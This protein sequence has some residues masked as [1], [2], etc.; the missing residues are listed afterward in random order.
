[1]DAGDFSEAEDFESLTS[2]SRGVE[3][4]TKVM[5]HLPFGVLVFDSAQ[6]LRFG[7]QRQAQLLGSDLRKVESVETWLRGGCRD[8][9]YADQVIQAWREHVWQ[10]QLIRV[11]S[12]KNADD[13]LRE[14]EFR[15]RL[16]ENGDLLVTLL[17][18]TRGRQA[19]DALRATETKLTG[20]FQQVDT[21]IAIVDP[22]G[23]FI[24]A[25]PAFEALL[26]YSRS[27]LRKMVLDDCLAFS[28][29][30]RLRAAELEMATKEGQVGD[31]TLLDRH[32]FSGD[33][34]IRLRPQEGDPFP[35]EVVM[36]LVMGPQR[37]RLYTM[38]FVRGGVE[39]GRLFDACQA[40]S[41]ALLEAIPDLILVMN[42]EG[43]I[44]DVMPANGGD[45][46]G[47]MATPEWKGQS[48]TACWPV[49]DAVAVAR[50]AEAIDE[51]KLRSWRFAEAG[52]AGHPVHYSVRVAPCE[53]DGAVVVVMDVTEEAVA[54][55]SRVRQSLAFQHLE[56][57]IIVT[58]LRGRIVDWN[59]A[60]ERIF[61]Y[62]L[63]EVAGEGLSK[64]YATAEERD[65]LNQ[66]ISRSLS[67]NGQWQT[68]R[69]FFRKD[70]SVGEAE[71]WFL[72]VEAEGAPRSLLGIH[73]EVTEPS[74][75]SDAGERMQH[76]WRN[77]LQAISGLLS[78]ELPDE[79]A[80]GSL[81]DAS[82][83]LKMQGR[84]RAISR[85]HE[86][87]ESLDA[88]VPLATYA[89]RLSEDLR[90]MIF[91][92][93]EM[94]SVPLFEVQTTEEEDAVTTSFE[95]ASTF[96]LLMVEVAIAALTH[97]SGNGAMILRNYEGSPLM[98]A[99]VPSEVMS[100]VSVPILKCLVDQL[101]GSLKVN[102]REGRAEWA[103][104][105]PAAI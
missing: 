66:E 60:A 98:Q 59:A 6:N 30:E 61:G 11:F 22:T 88:P 40:K 17:D 53:D 67:E 16:L 92:G 95:V 32:E 83:L 37:Q 57:G 10:K 102:H 91:G 58:N 39:S 8:K 14:I 44:E 104:R 48:V 15:P 29:I 73:R 72:P 81:I 25:N 19:E 47:V 34:A 74:L 49:F 50:V 41:R 101:R 36:S 43:T 3:D 33:E 63:N 99:S 62:S 68:R 46:R 75:D 51:Q 1:M 84:M 12:L 69:S 31:L 52:G 64:L 96:G 89:R 78:L 5:E 18:V 24:D 71:V 54:R 45:W 4:L 82:L 28:D 80:Q 55:E 42:R 79:I 27:E 70:G 103:L 23:R 20:I 87:A 2:S 65:A 93:I 26:G 35:A 77:Q 105:F 7:N 86:L 21:G 85:L 13:Q 9:A 56:E 100:S 76:R 90:R 94:E 97:R 38:L